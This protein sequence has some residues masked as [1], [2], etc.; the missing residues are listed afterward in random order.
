MRASEVL[1]KAGDVLRERGW[2]QGDFGDAAGR[3]CV[4][5]CI[6]VAINGVPEDQE[7]SRPYSHYL[8]AAVDSIWAEIWNDKTG[9]TEDDARVALDAAYVMALQEEGIEPEDVL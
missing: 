2:C 6:G 1:R 9:R 4:Y 8:E 7:G 5:G 3:V